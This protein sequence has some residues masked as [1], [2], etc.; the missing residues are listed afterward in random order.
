MKFMPIKNI[1]GVLTLFC[2]FQTLE[3]AAMTIIHVKKAN[4]RGYS[5]IVP[6]FTVCLN[7]FLIRALQSR[8][9]HK[10]LVAEA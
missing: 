8:R 1:A 5:G 9:F 6:P 4:R 3:L 2:G 10:L 7:V